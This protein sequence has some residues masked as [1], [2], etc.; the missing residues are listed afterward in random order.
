MRFGFATLPTGSP[1][2]TVTLFRLA[3]DLGFSVGWMPDQTFC[4]DPYITLA[5]CA[6]GTTRI[7]LGLGVTNPTT[8][9]PAMTARAAATL[10]ELAGGRFILGLGAGNR[11][12]LLDLLGLP[13]DRAAA[14]CREATVTIRRLLAGE[15]VDYRSPTLTMQGVALEITSLPPAPV[16]LAARGPQILRAAGEV[17]DGVIIGALVSEP[18]LRFALDHV[19]AGAQRAGRTLQA[20]EVVSWVTTIVTDR[21][22]EVMERLR[23]TVAHIV[24]G[25]PPEVLQA[26]GL[27]AERIAA[28]KKAYGAGGPLGAAPLVDPPLADALTIVGP[29]GEVAERVQTLAR[30]GVGQLAVLMPGGRFGSHAFPDFDHRTNL[31]RIAEEVIP[32][33][34][35]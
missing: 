5:A 11:K 15:R 31:R 34:G 14:R 26:I 1:A 21:K 4:R 9:H 28:F 2:E 17:A 8:R 33:V 10:A 29:P 13:T 23:P 3:E 6:Q 32:R 24:G 35:A 22:A 25:A 19:R 16:Y 27:S 18:G 30:A 20:L 7:T 12:E